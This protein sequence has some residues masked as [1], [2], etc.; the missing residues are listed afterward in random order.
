VEAFLVVALACVLLGLALAALMAARHL[1]AHTAR[2]PGD[3]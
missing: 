1:L 2:R 3:D